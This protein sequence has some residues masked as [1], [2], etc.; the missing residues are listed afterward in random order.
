MARRNAY[1]IPAIMM[2][3]I[4]LLYHRLA[5]GYF[6]GEDYNYL[7]F[8]RYSLSGKPLAPFYNDYFASMWFRPLTVMLWYIAWRVVGLTVWAHYAIDA[9]ILWS[10][11]LLLY[12]ICRRLGSS[13]IMAA[14]AAALFIVNPITADT[15]YNLWERGDLLGT[16][17]ALASIFLHL[18]S[19]KSKKSVLL[20]IIAVLATTAA[21]LCKE[22]YFI[23]PLLVLVIPREN[24]DKRR[25]YY[26]LD[27][28]IV[29]LPYLLVAAFVFMWRGAVIGHLL[30]GYMFKRSGV[31]ILII[32]T[33]VRFIRTL[34]LSPK[35]IA[36]YGLNL[37]N[38]P[39]SRL[40]MA[41]LCIVGLILWLLGG[42]N[43]FI[44]RPALLAL[45]WAVLS[46][47]PLSNFPDILEISPRLLYL[48]MAMFV[49]WL[50]MLRPDMKRFIN[51]P[52]L[53]LFAA[54]IPLNS[55]VLKHGLLESGKFKTLA[56]ATREF[57]LPYILKGPDHQTVI[58]FGVPPE[59][60][61]LSMIYM[62][63]LPKNLD[64]K[65]SPAFSAR[66]L[67]GD[68]PTYIG[69]VRRPGDHIEKMG[70][71][72]QYDY[73]TRDHIKIF[74]DDIAYCEHVRE[75]DIPKLISEN[76]NMTV[77]YYNAE[78][79][80]YQDVTPW[81]R[82][83]NST[84][85]IVLQAE[86]IFPQWTMD[87]GL[88]A[89]RPNDQLMRLLS[90]TTLLFRSDGNDP[91]LTLDNVL[92]D[93]LPIKRLDIKMRVERAGRFIPPVQDAFLSW[94]AKKP[95]FGLKQVISFPI[96]ADGEWHTYQAQVGAWPGW[97]L[98]G[99]ITSLRFD[100]ISTPGKVEIESIFAAPYPTP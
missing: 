63:M 93:P 58:V 9:V 37:F 44:S 89:W 24:P 7:W 49:I 14:F 73:E 32:Q 16:F 68:R 65:T 50:A 2:L 54:W 33:P 43:K 51:L 27:Q 13:P 36:T 78:T 88:N 34:G 99:M 12:R 55:N 59:A 5:G 96:K 61:S 64:V 11:A 29:G 21:C 26:L 15:L 66:I 19:L 4:L 47:L 77:G 72:D 87:N 83:V 48:P 98:G 25:I 70:F 86:R 91:F 45:L 40:M 71:Q 62:D 52:V 82:A 84:R 57:Y 18:Q 90:Q 23:V 69:V 60:Y 3:W 95:P 35:L 94:E 30:G 20:R 81:F 10:S 56:N 80:R 8:C 42:L 31:S 39:V 75:P 76:A 38:S 41:L 22:M 1:V 92:I 79:G 17:F 6:V 74:M 100:P 53:L 97:Y 85:R 67:L 28:L 46:I